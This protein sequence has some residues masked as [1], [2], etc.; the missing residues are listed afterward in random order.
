VRLATYKN[1]GTIRL[2]LQAGEYMIDLPQALATEANGSKPI[3]QAEINLA[4]FPSTTTAF[5]KAGR[6][7]MTVAGQVLEFVNTEENLNFLER[8]GVAH[9]LSK[10]EYL[11]PI[12]H[13][14]KM[15]CIGLNYRSHI[16][17]MD[18][19]LPEYPVLFAKFANSLIGHEQEIELPTVSPMLDYEAE[20][21]VV[22]GEQ[23]KNIS[24][25][26]AAT[27]I[28][29]Y[30]IFNDG[31]VR[32]Y[33]WRTGQWLQGKNFDNTSPIG[34]VIVTADEIADPG[35]LDI[36]LRLNGVIMQR[37][38]TSDLVFDVPALVSYLSEIMTLDPGDLI[39]TGTP[40]GVG[41]SRDP[42]VF[43]KPG[44]LVEVEIGQLGILR[45]MVVGQT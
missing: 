22:I 15:V 6:P 9:S 11:P 40:G 35:S 19:E 10:I 7:A 8:S 17:E 45:N 21:V 12:R 26:E 3:Y 23:C 18:R 1:E 28:G 24:P 41:F 30:T 31:S 16:L 5:L 37:S 14:G 27:C 20:L 2:G 34:P 4:T 33:Q 25:G 42:Q 44:D 29:G 43:L 32:D 39:A 13:P 36:E 38:N